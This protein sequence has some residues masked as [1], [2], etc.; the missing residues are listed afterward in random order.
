MPWLGKD[1]AIY[2]LVLSQRFQS[3]HVLAGSRQGV[4]DEETLRML[5]HHT[6]YETIEALH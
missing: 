5:G 1:Q 3:Q 6:R 4:A 2:F